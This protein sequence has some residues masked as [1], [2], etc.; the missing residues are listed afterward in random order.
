MKKARAFGLTALANVALWAAVLFFL[1]PTVWT[2]T[3]AFKP[4]N[5]YYVS[6]PRMLPRNPTT[7]HFFEAFYPQG[8]KQVFDEA[9]AYWVEEAAGRT[10]PVTP[11][12]VNSLFITLASAGLALLIGTPA[13]YALSRYDF[14][15]GKNM[16]TWL[17]STR[18]V[19][20]VVTVIP[21][22]FV[23]NSLRL[24]DKPLGLII[25]YVMIN[26]PIVVWILKGVFDEVPR[27]L[28]ESAR[29]DGCSPFTSFTRIVFPLAVG[30]MVAAGLF[31]IFLS[32]NEFLFALIMTRRETI[33]LPV[34]LS[35]FR[36]DRGMLWGMMSASIVVATLPVVAII[37]VLQKRIVQGLLTGSNR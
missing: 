14:R 33:T 13:A 6:P 1:M 8:A 30:G 26:L 5:E 35:T 24:V 7:Y 4:P 29:V 27:E 12:T 21:M 11:A 17:L 16:A 18:M 25:L 34:A 37:F 28:E 32:W 36:L 15:G 19:P 23:I 20:P 9:T 10:N 2:W 3:T 22:F 31:A